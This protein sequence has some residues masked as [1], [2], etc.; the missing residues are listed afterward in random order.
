MNTRTVPFLALVM[1]A[2]ASAAEVQAPAGQL[3]MPG[4]FQSRWTYQPSWSPDGKYIAFLWDDWVTQ[5]IYIV[6]VGGGKPVRVSGA[7]SFIGSPS[8]NSAGEAPSWSPDSRHI[9]Y[10]Q[11]GDIFLTSV[12]DGKITRLTETQG[13]ESG[14]RFSPDGKK[15]AFGKDGDLYV[16]SLADARIVQLT[17][18][19]KGDGRATWSPDGKWIA[20]ERGSSEHVSWSPSVSGTRVSYNWSKR[21]PADAAVVSSHGGAVRLVAAT[22][23]S[24]SF[25][26]WSPDSRSLLIERRSADARDRTLLLAPIDGSEAR[27]LMRQ[28]ESTFLQTHDKTAMFSPG[29]P[30]VAYTGDAD[31]WNHIYL[32]D[33]ETGKVRQLTSGQFEVS[34]MNWRKPGREIVF[35]STENGTEQRQIYSV[36]VESGKRTRLTQEP[37][38]NTTAALSPA[39]DS[40]LYLRSDPTHLPDVWVKSLSAGSTARRLTDAMSA[41]LHKASWQ[42]P[43]IVTYPSRA[44]QFPIKAQLFV[45]PHLDPS[46]KYPAIVH[47]HQAAIYQE[48]YLG[49]GPMKDNVAWYGFNQH[50]A[51]EGYVVLNVD[52]R[53]SSGYGRDFAA[54]DYRDLGGKDAVDAVSGVDYLKSLGYVDTDRVGVYGM[55]YGGHMV[56]SLL[57]KFPDV[58]KAG[59]D[60]AGVADFVLNYE[61]L[62]GSWII[63]R[64]GTPE[65]NPQGYHDSSAINFVEQMKAP[66][67]IL[68][69]TNDPNVTLLQSIEL[70][71][72]LLK[73]GKRFEFEIYPGELHFFTKKSS[74]IDAFAKMDRFFQENVVL[75]K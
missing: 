58:F 45:P 72:R 22:P 33:L 46:H 16:I 55:S 34:F 51:D 37:G 31:G 6:P 3:T 75:A 9:L 23:D 40:V 20:F 11:D 56:L 10:T 42:T 64:L 50:L 7:R 18:Q 5:N 29:G 30:T 48:V 70:V 67:M 14:P 26:D 1:L 57:T 28:H 44:G 74:W 39:G 17:S 13:A 4:F 19:H 32:A 68:H 24:E 69:G 63:G 47:T 52:Y 53:G 36:D 2:H 54:A 8:F 21:G 35:C 61:S 27:V 65:Q 12:P 73:L 25:T 49:P 62:Y 41:E 60:I 38:V 15:I 43:R 59:V 71:D 66:V